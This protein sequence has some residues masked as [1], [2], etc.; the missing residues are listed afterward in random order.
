M[1]SNGSRHSGSRHS[2]QVPYRGCGAWLQ[3]EQQHV[4]QLLILTVKQTST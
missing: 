2:A 3:H 1:S 4:Q